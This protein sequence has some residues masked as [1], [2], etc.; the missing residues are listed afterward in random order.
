MLL[1]EMFSPIGG[2]KEDDQ[3]IDWI[4]DLKFYMDNEDSLL[5]RHIFPAVKTH[6]K[7]LGHPQ[8]YK[9]YLHAIKPCL[10][11]YCK[12]FEIE[13]PEEKFPMEQLVELAKYMASEQ[14]KFIKEGDYKKDL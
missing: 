13:D 1:R 6:E 4:D 8:I 9:V 12:T 7:H 10:E 2:P 5:N 11:D 14:E 3:D